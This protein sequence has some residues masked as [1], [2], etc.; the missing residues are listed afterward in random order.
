MLFHV[1]ETE[2]IALKMRLYK[3]GEW[4]NQSN[5]DL[6]ISPFGTSPYCIHILAKIGC[7][8]WC[9]TCTNFLELQI[10][11]DDYLHRT[12]TMRTCVGQTPRVMVNGCCVVDKE[13]PRP[14]PLPTS[15]TSRYPRAYIKLFDYKGPHYQALH[16]SYFPPRLTASGLNW[17]AMCARTS[18]VE[19]DSC[20]SPL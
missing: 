14:R 6:W 2:S 11:V 17:P 4:L 7:I 12:Y 8:S 5:E 20:N 19:K 16:Y 10:F 15:D 3:L 1:K 13:P 9:P 18:G